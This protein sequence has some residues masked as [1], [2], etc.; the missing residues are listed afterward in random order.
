MIVCMKTYTVLAP[1]YFGDLLGGIMLGVILSGLVD[2]VA[3]A[4]CNSSTC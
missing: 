3:I 4:F 1:Q 2:K